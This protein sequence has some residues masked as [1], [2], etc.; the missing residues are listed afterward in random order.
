MP[1]D[2]LPQGVY[3][4]AMSAEHEGGALQIDGRGSR[5][6]VLGE[7]LRRAVLRT[8]SG[9]VEKVTIQ[10]CRPGQGRRRGR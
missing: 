5:E 3:L 10:V 9:Q 8:R 7:L 6:A 4:R 2:L 1:S